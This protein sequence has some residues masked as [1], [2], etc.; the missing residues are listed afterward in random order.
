MIL[1]FVM[2]LK[3]YR[4][5]ILAHTWIGSSIRD[6]QSLNIET[7]SSPRKTF[8]SSQNSVKLIILKL[9]K[10][11]SNEINYG[12]NTYE[13]DATRSSLKKGLSSDTLRVRVFS[14]AFYILSKKNFYAVKFFGDK[15]EVF[16]DLR[17]K[18]S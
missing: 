18:K 9:F 17:G 2:I 3:W 4:N 12:K 15:P 10:N 6:N 8:G 16:W 5:A 13:V 11:S 1:F 7:F 14:K